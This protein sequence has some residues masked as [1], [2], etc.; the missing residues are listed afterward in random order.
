MSS[1][2]P[3]TRRTSRP[4]SAVG[5]LARLL[6][7]AAL[8]AVAGLLL[9]LA[10][11][12]ARREPS[13]PTPALPT[14]HGQAAWSRS[15]RPA[16][17]FVLTDQSGR[18]ITLGRGGPRPL[19]VAFL[20]SSAG[21]AS[22]PEGRSLAQTEQL[23]PAAVRP[24]LDVVSVDPAADTPARIR[25]AAADWG[26]AA[27]GHYHWLV[28][29]TGVLAAVWRAY[30]VSA[31]RGTGQ[32]DSSPLVYLI[33]RRGFERVGYVYPFFPTVMARDLVTLARQP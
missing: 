15:E 6:R 18:S 2:A 30:G 4:D 5:V 19:V 3:T 24:V 33:D 32:P 17:A 9:G 22:A 10:V 31:A 7:W 29:P 12:L 25:T 21:H 23:L 20:A 26:L 1:P 27:A 13:A 8:A 28:G 11:N 16:P 14:F